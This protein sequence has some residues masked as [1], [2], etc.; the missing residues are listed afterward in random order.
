MAAAHLL[1]TA[2]NF[3]Q[4]RRKAIIL[5]S[6]KILTQLTFS[7]TTKHVSQKSVWNDWNVQLAT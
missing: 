7:P 2:T 5:F 3:D 4:N 6:E 1:S